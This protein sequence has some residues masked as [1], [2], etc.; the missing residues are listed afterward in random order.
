[1]FM[2]LEVSYNTTSQYYY[3]C[4]SNNTSTS[5][6]ISNYYYYYLQT[7]DSID[8]LSIT[9]AINIPTVNQ[10][11]MEQAQAIS[12]INYY[13]NIG[14][15]VYLLIT[16]NYVYYTFSVVFAIYCCKIVFSIYNC[17]NLLIVRVF[18]LQFSFCFDLQNFVFYFEYRGFSSKLIRKR[19][20]H[21]WTP[22]I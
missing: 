3:Y 22:I 17:F 13:S 7:I 14:L 10:D 4:Y 20:S 6:K 15:V 2:P 8:F 16:H 11:S 12:T 18:V 9:K 1:M 19:V 21:N 5:T